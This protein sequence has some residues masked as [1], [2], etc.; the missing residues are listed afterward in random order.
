M[1]EEIWKPVAGTAGVYEVS[2]MG[3][4]RRTENGR[5]LRPRK[6]TS[7]GSLGVL[8]SVYGEKIP[9]SLNVLIAETFVPN[10]QG[11]RYVKFLDGDRTNYKA[12]NLAWCDRG[13]LGTRR[14][15]VDMLSAG[16]TYI[17]TFKS[18]EEASKI[19]KISA[20]AIRRALKNYWNTAGGFRWRYHKERADDE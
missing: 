7:S 12:E 16:G 19:K 6:T 8:M 15:A 2:N 10:P 17:R 11:K 5:I 20:S 4:V 1:N 3:R 18:T 9:K 14:M 13:E